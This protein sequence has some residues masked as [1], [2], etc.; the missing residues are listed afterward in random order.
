[1]LQRKEENKMKMQT[2][3]EKIVTNHIS[4]NRLVFEYINNSYNSKNKTNNP[5]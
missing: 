5:I 2:K 3:W 1:M 4:D